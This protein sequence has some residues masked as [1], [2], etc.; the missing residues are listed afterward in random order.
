MNV[1][2]VI[3]ILSTIFLNKIL[4]T[5]FFFYSFYHQFVTLLEGKKVF[6]FDI[7]CPIN[8]FRSHEMRKCKVKL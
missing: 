6:Y 3:L 4:L 7:A 8:K 2:Q 5:S 1:I